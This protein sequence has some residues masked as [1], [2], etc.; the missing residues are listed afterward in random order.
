MNKPR[1]KRD[2]T[3]REVFYTSVIVTLAAIALLTHL[4]VVKA[5]EA[6]IHVIPLGIAF[7]FKDKFIN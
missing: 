5:K 6:L 4:D 1:P 2:L 3:K 7:A